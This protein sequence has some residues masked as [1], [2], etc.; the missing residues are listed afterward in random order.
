MPKE[1]DNSNN[2][3]RAV[4]A[5]NMSK[6]VRGGPR[7]YRSEEARQR[8]LAYMRD[9]MRKHRSE[10][11]PKERRRYRSDEQRRLLRIAAVRRLQLQRPLMLKAHRA[12]KSAIKRGELLLPGF[13]D[14]SDCGKPATEYDHRDY[15][16]PLQ[17]EPVCHSCNVLRGAG[18]PYNQGEA[19]T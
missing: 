15:T 19:R 7:I 12:V 11:Q 4:S 18:Y 2:A 5:G 1:F 14:C 17:V 8:H 6:R 13:R 9:Y 16:V 3:D 10:L